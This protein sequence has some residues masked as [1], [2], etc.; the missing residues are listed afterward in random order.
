LLGG[1]G[2][3]QTRREAANERIAKERASYGPREELSACKCL[4]LLVAHAELA[5]DLLDKEILAIGVGAGHRYVFYE[6][7]VE[8]GLLPAPPEASRRV[9][10]L[11]EAQVEELW[12]HNKAA[13][14]LAKASA[15]QRSGQRLSI[16]KVRRKKTDRSAEAGSV[17]MRGQRMTVRIITDEFLRTQRINKYKYEVMSARSEFNGCVDIIYS[18]PSIHLSAGHTYYVQVNA[19]PQRPRV[20]KMFRE[21]VPGER[22]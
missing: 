21:I 8:R 5:L 20:I 3:R 12:P 15:A 7:F 14:K 10:L 2:R 1:H 4:G 11:H 9:V 16:V 17:G 13:D 18:E 19:E 22:A 6:L